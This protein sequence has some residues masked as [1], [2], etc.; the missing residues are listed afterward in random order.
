MSP[1]V[2]PSSTCSA[3]SRVERLLHAQGGADRPVGVVLV[4]DGCAEEGDDGVAEDLVDA[5]AECFDL[6][7]ERLEVGVDEAGHGLRIEVLGERGVADEVGEQHGDDAPFLDRD[8]HIL[9]RLSARRTET[10]T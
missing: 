1:A 2:S 5:T 9:G 6:G 8:R 7:D 10:G 3:T 4:G